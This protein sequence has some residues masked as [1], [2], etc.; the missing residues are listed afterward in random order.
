VASGELEERLGEGAIALFVNGGGGDVN[1]LV[2]GVRAR[3]NGEYTVDTMVRGIHYYG[4]A[5][6]QPRFRIG[7]RG[8]GTFEEAEELGQAVAEEAW[9]VA[10]TIEVSE[11][12]QPPWVGSASVRL[13]P[14]GAPPVGDQ[15][16]SHMGIGG[17][18]VAEVAAFGVGDVACVGEPGEVFAETFVDFKRR[19]WQMGF[20]VPMAASY[21]DGFFWYLPPALAFP[22][23]GMEVER[24]RAAGLREDMQDVMWAALEAVIHSR[25]RA[26]GSP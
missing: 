2:S 7:D 9:R 11:P 24:A 25:A 12:Q 5:D 20:R 14:P 18:A 17:E 8:G 19:L 6:S 26:S 23:G 4:T 13:R 16:P 10:Q 3:L 1:P 15:I 22:E 21:M